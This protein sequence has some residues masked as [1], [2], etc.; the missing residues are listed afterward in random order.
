MLQVKA[1]IPGYILLVLITLCGQT[2]HCQTQPTGSGHFE[3]LRLILVGKTGTG[4]STSGNIILNRRVFEEGI[5][6]N[7]VTE[8]CQRAEEKHGDQNI[9]V[10]DTPGLFDTTKS[11]EDLKAKI[12]K[13]IEV[14]V[15]GPH[16]FLLVISL[17]SRF[18]QEEQDTVKW[19][20]ENFGPDASLYT[21]ILFTHANLLEDKTVEDYV[22][23][24]RN[25]QRLINS[26]GGRYHSFTKDLENRAQVE[27]LLNKIEQMVEFNGGSYYTNEM[28]EE[29]QKKL[30]KN[31]W[32]CKT[33]LAA[34][35]LPFILGVYALPVSGGAAVYIAEHCT[36]ELSPFNLFPK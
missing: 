30:R 23:E 20:Q 7:S 34:M 4:K 6:P 35:G 33:A 32:S 18:T 2:A 1:W 29:A 9:V 31:G 13:C 24:S 27:E 25:L 15:P 36:E 16:A 12:E 22:K 3:E 5:S 17:K 11:Q 10:I 19:I 28:Y 14:S 26:C 21:V 8:G